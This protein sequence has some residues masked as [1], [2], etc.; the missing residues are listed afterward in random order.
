MESLS[1]TDARAQLPQLL[2][3]VAAGESFTITRHGADIAVLTGH[4]AWMKTRT[5]DVILR[6]RELRGEIDA[7]RGKPLDLSGP[8]TVPAETD[9]I[10]AELQWSKGDYPDGR[11]V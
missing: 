2:D 11:E 10:I 6:A 9:A 1:L 8:T 5:H 3:R 7:A 4:D